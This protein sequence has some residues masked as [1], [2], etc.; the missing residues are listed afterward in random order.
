MNEE[1]R[2]VLEKYKTIICRH[3]LKKYCNKGKNCQFAHGKDELRKP[4]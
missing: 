2:N 4:F 1:R 3:F